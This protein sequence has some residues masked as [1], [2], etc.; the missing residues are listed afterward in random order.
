MEGIFTLPYSEYEVIVQLQKKFSKK[1]GFAFYIPTSRQ[2]KGID[3]IIHNDKKNIMKRIQVKSSR[4]Y[5][6]TPK[7]LKSGKV[8][9][10]KY[11]YNLWFNNFIDKYDKNNAD[12]YILF[13]LFPVYTQDEN[14][15][16]KNIFW[17]SLIL[18]FNEKEMQEL[19]KQVKT[20]REKKEDK[21]FG[22]GFNTEKEIF[23]T[24]GFLNEENKSNFLLDNKVDSI[25][26]EFLR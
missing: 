10:V 15:K 11:K 13:G 7:T 21:F 26:S 22:F 3:F 23:A 16:S 5:V 20:K 14:I 6:D 25:K 2:Q 19:L 17:K 18:C 4:S 8:K 9:S 24:R 12:Y 1:E